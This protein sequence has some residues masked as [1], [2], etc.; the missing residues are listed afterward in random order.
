MWEL[1]VKEHSKSELNLT[2]ILNKLALNTQKIT[3]E[4]FKLQTNRMEVS[5]FFF[6]IYN[7]KWNNTFYNIIF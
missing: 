3:I 6:N 5:F 2:K 7:E 4:Q 1:H